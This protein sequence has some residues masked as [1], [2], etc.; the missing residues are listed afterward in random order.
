MTNDI[1]HPAEE[2]TAT[3]LFDQIE[4]LE[5]DLA[6]LRRSQQAALEVIH[7]HRKKL[8]QITAR[9]NGSGR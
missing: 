7:R 1:D 6:A 9:Q 4:K 8:G 5:R 3:R 2:L